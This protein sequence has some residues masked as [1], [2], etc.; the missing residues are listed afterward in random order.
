MRTAGSDAQVA[1]ETS[2]GALPLPS[3]RLLTVPNVLSFA[4]L[5][6]VPLFLWLFTTGREDA[7]VLLYA[8]GAW[9]DFFDGYLARRLGQVSVVGKVLDPL[10]DRVF[11]VAL[12]LALVARGLLPLGLTLAIVARDLLIVGAF[13]LL[14]RR[15]V[16][17]LEVSLTGK[18]ATALLLFGLTWL[19]CAATDL[20]L[21]SAA[22]ED[23]GSAFVWAGAV[24]YW[25]AAVQYARAAV[26]GLVAGRKP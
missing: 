18:T 17:R 11:I 9:T 21:V 20:P 5:A 8:A 13:P 23:V 16:P 3:R 2:E 24:L 14:E 7:A 6:T 22:G 10:A 12:A 4:R 1:E 15:G 26:G 25:V 19:A